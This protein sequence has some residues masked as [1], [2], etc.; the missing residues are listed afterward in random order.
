MSVIQNA[1][2][3]AEMFQWR[4]WA[5]TLAILIGGGVGIGAAICIPVAFGIWFFKFLG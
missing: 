1:H 3:D 4:G 2:G 5:L